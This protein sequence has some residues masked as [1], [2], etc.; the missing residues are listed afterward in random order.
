[1][2]RKNGQPLSLQLSYNVENA[3]RR[4]VT[5]QLQS[6]LKQAGIDATI[7]AYPANV[8]FATYGQ[9][10]ILTNGKYDIAVGGWVAGIDP[11]DHSLYRCDQIPPAGT[12]YTRYCSKEMDAQQEIA[13]SEYDPARRKPA[14]LRIQ[15][16]L[17]RDVP[18]NYLWFAAFPNAINPDFKGFAPNP[19]NEAWNAYEWEI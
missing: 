10:G 1:M 13:L 19:I 11:D 16:L 14:Y 2:M 7:K 5:V 17:A 15:E 6:T 12:N 4:L 18:E 9:G 3:T 8:F